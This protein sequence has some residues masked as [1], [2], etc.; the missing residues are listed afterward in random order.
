ML[1][2]YCGLLSKSRYQKPD[3]FMKSLW[4]LQRLGELTGKEKIRECPFWV[5]A[6]ARYCL[7]TSTLS[8][9]AEYRGLLW[10]C[11]MRRMS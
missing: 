6:Q 7:G 3:L 2:S 5:Q 11:Y 8:L 10:T 4:K 9:L 1:G